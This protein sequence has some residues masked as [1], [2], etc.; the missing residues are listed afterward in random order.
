MFQMGV[1]TQG[2]AP[3]IVIAESSGMAVVTEKVRE[4]RSSAKSHT[5]SRMV[6][7]IDDY[8]DMTSTAIKLGAGQDDLALSIETTQEPS[9]VSVDD[10]TDQVR[11]KFRQTPQIIVGFGGGMTMDTAKAV[12]SLLTNCGKA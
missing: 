11:R 10:V 2:L 9:T 3:E 1:V 7:L 5:C 6:F 12:A 4:A 8:F